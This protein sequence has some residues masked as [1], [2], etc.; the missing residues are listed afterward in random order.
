MFT[1]HHVSHVRCQV[2]GV[3]CQ[4]SGVMCQVYFL[5][6]FYKVV[7]LVLEGML[8]TVPTP[9]SLF[10]VLMF[11]NMKVELI[12]SHMCKPW[13]W[14]SWR[15]EC[16]NGLVTYIFFQDL[17]TWVKICKQKPCVIIDQTDPFQH[18]RTGRGSPEGNRPSTLLQEHVNPDVTFPLLSLYINLFVTWMLIS[19]WLFKSFIAGCY[20]Y[21]GMKT[22]VIVKN[23]K[24][25]FFF[26]I[27]HFSFICDQDKINWLLN[28][29]GWLFRVP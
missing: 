1:P 20:S 16:T 13:T 19:I 17:S 7:E 12:L 4:V 25:Y 9:S 26:T 29:L 11:L 14:A 27:L 24:K 18:R 3:M 21:P 2:S 5:F 10:K 15:P 8:S 6:F 28:K 23:Q 22:I